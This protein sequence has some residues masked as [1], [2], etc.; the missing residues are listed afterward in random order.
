MVPENF[1]LDKDINVFCVTAKAFPNGIIEAFQ[2]LENLD[3]SICE[4]PFY[5]ISYQNKEG[6]TV[7]KAAVAEV[8]DGE[9]KEY[10]CE[11]FAIKSGSY[12]AIR[13]FDFME[14]LDV[15]PNAFRKLLADR[16]L[17]KNF[18]CVEWYIS[19][20]EVMCMVRIN[21]SKNK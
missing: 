12:S 4:R 7:Y 15:I 20:K 13:L 2:T 11:T 14:K 21:Q 3:P 17:D 5:G 9:G 8:F 16:R 10:G 6:D 1:I 19:S 18:P